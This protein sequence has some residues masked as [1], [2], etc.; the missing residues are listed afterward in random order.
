MKKRILW[1]WLVLCMTA[2]QVFA[3]RREVHILSANDMHATIGALPTLAAIADS[4][5]GT[6]GSRD[7]VMRLGGDEFVVILREEDFENRRSLL[8]TLNQQMEKNI[9]S[10][11]MVISAGISDYVNGQDTSLRSVFEQADERMY[12]R[13]KELKQRTGREI[14][15]NRHG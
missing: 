4:L 1:L 11:E 15:D 13:K 14:R 5:R 6:F 12:Q 7:V 8:D 3:D 2:A 10:G 9:A